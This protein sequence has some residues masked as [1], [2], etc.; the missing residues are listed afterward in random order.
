M[1]SRIARLSLRG[2]C[3]PR[4]HKTHQAVA[5]GPLPRYLA[6]LANLRRWETT[7]TTIVT[8]IPATTTVII[9]FARAS[10]PSQ[11]A[12]VDA[13]HTQCTEAAAA[14]HASGVQARTK[15]HLPRNLPNQA[16]AAVLALLM[17]TAPARPHR[18]L[19]HLLLRRRRA[20]SR[21]GSAAPRAS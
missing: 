15:K 9:I 3:R 11:D 10:R 13:V 12:S 1:I 6:I 17:P 19:L 2:A 21:W 4:R 18:H 14:R 5:Y 7:M 20:K 16:P 8:L